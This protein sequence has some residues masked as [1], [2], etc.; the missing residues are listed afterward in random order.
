MIG[1]TYSCTL[2]HNESAYYISFSY[3][4]L[5]FIGPSCLGNYLAN[6]SKS[7]FLIKITE[8]NK[9]WPDQPSL[10]K[11]LN[12]TLKLHTESL[13]DS[14]CYLN[15]PQ[16][17]TS[18]VQLTSQYILTQ[19]LTSNL[20]VSQKRSNSSAVNDSERYLYYATY[21]NN[22]LIYDVF[23]KSVKCIDMSNDGNRY[24]KNSMQL[25]GEYVFSM[26]EAYI[27]FKVRSEADIFH[28]SGRRL[29]K[30]PYQFLNKNGFALC[31][32]RGY[33]Y[34]FG[35]KDYSTYRNTNER[36]NLALNTSQKLPGMRFKRAMLSCVA[37]GNKIY[38][39]RGSSKS[40]DLFNTYTLTFKEVQILNEEPLECHGIA[41]KI[42]NMVY[43]IT[44]SYIQI[45]NTK[46][47]KL[48]QISLASQIYHS[49]AYSTIYHSNHLYYF[50][51]LTRKIQSQSLSYSQSNPVLDSEDRNLRWIYIYDV[52]R[53]VL[54]ADVKSKIVEKV[55]EDAG[56][57]VNS[58]CSLPSG[59][60]FILLDPNDTCMLIN[61]SYNSIYL[62]GFN[63]RSDTC[64]SLYHDGN[65][66]VFAYDLRSHLYMVSLDLETKTWSNLLEKRDLKKR[67]CASYVGI[68]DKI[69]ILGGGNAEV[70]MYH[71]TTNSY[72]AYIYKLSSSNAVS[73]VI[74]DEIY[75]IQ[76]NTY[77][78]FDIN[79]ELIKEG[80]SRCPKYEVYSKYNVAFYE[81][82]LYFIN[83]ET[84]LLEYFDI[85]NQER[86]AEAIQFL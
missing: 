76:K 52:S 73:M 24:F 47:F 30:L 67:Y 31:Y 79:F 62:P 7:H 9:V 6:S 77:Q 19:S 63:K 3:R 42:E 36:L 83:E 23:K 1:N 44:K 35:G 27:E 50:N 58:V 82:K 20:L 12:S 21:S 18:P 56:K 54:R 32:H 33:M 64:S 68:G 85:R 41:F 71:I 22:F 38:L 16:N 13:L 17:Q 4:E 10:L 84:W 78:I 70:D 57:S 86:R 69:Y 28:R 61:C 26:S 39:F 2:C 53:G 48:G 66:Y 11:Y 81:G 8:V 74:G 75:V 5:T 45:Y 40:I 80:E 15:S 51:P 46:L 72:T 59:E 29:P 34:L 25:V 55:I 43:L 60:A 65:I 37:I 14:L 49:P